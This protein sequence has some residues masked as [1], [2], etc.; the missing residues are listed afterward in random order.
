MTTPTLIL[1]AASVLAS[2]VIV[3]HARLRAE[4]GRL[5]RQRVNDRM[6]PSTR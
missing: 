2:R 1:L 5:Q 4:R 3:T 6:K